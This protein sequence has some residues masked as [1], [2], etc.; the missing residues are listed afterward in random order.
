M[1]MIVAVNEPKYFLWN[2]IFFSKF[3]VDA[4]SCVLKSMIKEVWLTKYP[5]H[6]EVTK[7]SMILNG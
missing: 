1:L 2:S 5:E 4:Y 3:N 6:G 7:L